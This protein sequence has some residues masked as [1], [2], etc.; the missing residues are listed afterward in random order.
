MQILAS[1]D[2]EA[3]DVFETE[4]AAGK[5]LLV[6]RS[7]AWED[8]MLRK[9]HTIVSSIHDLQTELEQR[10]RE[11]K[12]AA[13]PVRKRARLFEELQVEQFALNRTDAMAAATKA[14]TDKLHAEIR[15]M[16]AQKAV[17]EREI[18]YAKVW[19]RNF[20]CVCGEL[21]V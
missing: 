9:T 16:D 19:P 8:R 14:E 1:V 11:D 4:D 6:G 12:D 7:H 10:M 3:A 18:K 20:S 2:E 5:N 21:C 13:Q 15:S 17:L